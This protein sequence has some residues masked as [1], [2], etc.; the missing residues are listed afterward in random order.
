MPAR[1]VLH[2]K[3][4]DPFLLAVKAALGKRGV[5]VVQGDAFNDFDLHLVTDDA[6]AGP[7]VI[8]IATLPIAPYRALIHP[9]LRRPFKADAVSYAQSK[10]LFEDL[11]SDHAKGKRFSAADLP[12]GMLAVVIAV[13]DDPATVQTMIADAVGSGKPVVLVAEDPMNSAMLAGLA[14]VFPSVWVYHDALA[15]TLHKVDA[16]VSRSGAGVILAHIHRT[17][18]ILYNHAIFDHISPVVG[19]E[20]SFKKA[21]AQALATQGIYA[22]YLYWYFQTQA[23]R[24]DA[25]DFADRLLEAFEKTGFARGLLGL[26]VGSSFAR[27]LSDTHTAAQ[28][29]TAFLEAQ[30]AFTSVALTKTLKVSPQS[31]VFQA[32]LNGEK[33]VI[34][35]FHDADPAHTVRSLQGELAFVDKAMGAGPLRVNRCLHA[36][37][38][39]GT[40]V[41]SYAGD[42]RLVDAIAALSGSARAALLTKAGAWLNTY[43]SSRNRATTFGPLHWIKELDARARHKLDAAGHALFDEGLAKLGQLAKKVMGSPVVQAATHGDYAGINV[44]LL[45]D[46]IIGVDIQGE[47]WQA[48]A[49]DAAQFLVW[50]ALHDPR[51]TGAR[52]FGL[53]GADVDAFLAGLPLLM[54]EHH[55]TIPFFMGRNIMHRLLDKTDRGADAAPELGLLRAYLDDLSTYLEMQP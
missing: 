15:D 49:K 29:L 33:V 37:P 35:R 13:D 46:Q 27:T 4:L 44:H 40:V 48:L 16:I 23:F 32:R 50:Q 30:P 52:C 12:I 41:L 36:W 34:K 45:E 53:D 2:A 6:V 54:A 17:P 10:A 28:T 22:K 38:Q 19:P 51:A 18:A 5:E 20:M 43:A 24:S 55:T 11:R 39:D 25:S 1:V 7:N 31:W 8:K 3:A 9:A 21:L 47:C 42:E 14:N 26:E